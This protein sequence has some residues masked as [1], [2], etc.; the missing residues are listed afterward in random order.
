M[1]VH[2]VSE[3]IMQ[4]LIYNANIQLNCVSFRV[5]GNKSFALTLM[6]KWNML[7]EFI[8]KLYF[9]R[10]WSD[11]QNFGVNPLRIIQF[12]VSYLIQEQGVGN[13]IV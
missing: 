8:A 12:L 2:L 13:K 6:Y 10:E 5:C 7:L 1:P 4:S 9:E 3:I 11:A